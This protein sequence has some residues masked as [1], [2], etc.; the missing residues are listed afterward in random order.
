MQNSICGHYRRLRQ[1]ACG[2][3]LWLD[4]DGGVQRVGLCDY[5]CDRRG[6][7]RALTVADPTGGDGDAS[8]A[9]VSSGENGD[10]G[11]AA[12]SVGAAAGPLAMHMRQFLQLTPHCLQIALLGKPKYNRL[13][14]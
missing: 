13:A 8:A 5:L 3:G 2:R 10:V 11:G 1:R 12:S 4:Y 7:A 9:S 14:T 6:L